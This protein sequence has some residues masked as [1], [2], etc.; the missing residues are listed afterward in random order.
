MA[1][2]LYS[3]KGVMSVHRENSSLYRDLMKGGLNKVINNPAEQRKFYEALHK[4]GSRSLGG[5]TRDTLERV[6]KDLGHDSSFSHGE[7]AAIAKQLVGKN[8]WQRDV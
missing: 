4:E 8:Y 5:I 7:R 2:V 3:N 6:V 1:K